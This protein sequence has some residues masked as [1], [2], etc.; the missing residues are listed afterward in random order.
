MNAVSCSRSGE[1]TSSIWMFLRISSTISSED[2]FCRWRGK[3]IQFFHDAQQAGA[4]EHL[5]GQAVQARLQIAGHVRNHILLRNRRL[6]HQNRGTRAVYRRHEPA[7]NPNTATQPKKK[8]RI[9]YQRRRRSSPSNGPS[10]VVRPRPVRLRNHPPSLPPNRLRKTVGKRDP[11]AIMVH[12]C[13]GRSAAGL[14][15]IISSVT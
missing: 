7:G 5:L 13:R 8:G 12:V 2:S 9:R 14:T 11:A 4:A 1:R 10:P 15:L 3:Q 6:L